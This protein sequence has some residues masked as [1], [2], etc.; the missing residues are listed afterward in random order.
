MAVLR[1]ASMLCPIAALFAL[2]G[3]GGSDYDLAPVSGKVMLNGEPRNRV[4]L[5]LRPGVAPTRKAISR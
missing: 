2:G 4:I 3:C 5:G 1:F